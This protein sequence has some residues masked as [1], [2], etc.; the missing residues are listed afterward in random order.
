[1]D[2]PTVSQF[3]RDDRVTCFLLVR[4]SAIR[5]D[6]KG[7]PY[8]D[9]NLSD[10]TGEINCK[11]WDS[12]A[13]APAPGSVIKVQGVVTEFKERL[14]LKVERMREATDED[15]VDMSLLVPSAPEPPEDMMQRVTDT[16]NAFR[17]EDLRKVVQE[18]LRMAGDSLLWFPA[19]QRIHHAERSGLLHHITSM[20][21]TA[22]H[23][24]QAYPFLNGDLIRAG[25][26][27][28]DIGKISEMKA[29]ETGNVTDYT[30]DG[31]LV[32]HLVRAVAQ[33]SEA[34][35]RV[36][37]SGEVVTLL[38]HI[39][40]SH[41]GVAEYGSPRPPMFMEAEVVRVIDDLD[42]KL[43]AM[44][45][46]IDRT[47]KGGFS[48]RIMSLDRRVYHPLFDHEPPTPAG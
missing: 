44:Q 20:L 37:V 31:L 46:V 33:V 35:Q 29:D 18:M 23:I 4:T 40:I 9:M 32:G 5:T 1:M 25:I 3:R 39:I 19:A 43:N 6:I 2:Q 38:E 34:A 28:H 22:E 36:G 12:N 14:Q 42:A 16:V 21:N 13:T 24:I 15:D 30:R 41:H 27:L 10:R 47:P 26:I 11:L 17:S 7:N 48:E 8:L 45:A